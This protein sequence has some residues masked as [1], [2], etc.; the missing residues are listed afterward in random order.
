[1]GRD[2]SWETFDVSGSGNEGD[3]VTLFSNEFGELKIR[4]HMAES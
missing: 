2:F 4:N 1:M 3:S